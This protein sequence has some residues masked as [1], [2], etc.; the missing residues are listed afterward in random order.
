MKVPGRGAGAHRGSGPPGDRGGDALPVSF[1]CRAPARHRAGT[2]RSGRG[3]SVLGREIG[4]RDGVLLTAAGIVVGVGLDTAGVVVSVTAGAAAAPR[5]RIRRV[6]AKHG[7]LDRL[8]SVGVGAE[9]PVAVQVQCPKVRDD[10]CLERVAHAL[11]S[12]YAAYGVMS[13]STVCSTG[14]VTHHR[15]A[16]TQAATTPLAAAPPAAWTASCPAP[17]SRIPAADVTGGPGRASRPANSFRARYT[18]DSGLTSH[19]TI[20]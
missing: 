20:V 7:V 13:A 8:L 17:C 18:A 6:P 5:P 1:G 15:T 3:G 12:A 14:S 11:P 4:G 2:D 10:R 19:K 16:M 9:H